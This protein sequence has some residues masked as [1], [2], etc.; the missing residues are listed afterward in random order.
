VAPP[1]PDRGR[2]GKASDG[3]ND[4]PDIDGKALDDS[5][6]EERRMTQAITEVLAAL[7]VEPLE[8]LA[9]PTEPTAAVVV[10]SDS[11]DDEQDPAKKKFLAKKKK[12]PTPY[13]QTLFQRARSGNTAAMA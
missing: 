5:D 6:M 2:D 7:P 13:V 3:I 12:S 10:P 8:D 4:L 11:S 9:T 1:A